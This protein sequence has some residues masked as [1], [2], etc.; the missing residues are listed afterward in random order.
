MNTRLKRI[1]LAVVAAAILLTA[2]IGFN[3][4]DIWRA[5]LF[6]P[7]VE[8]IENDSV[9]IGLYPGGATSA[10]VFTNDDYCGET[11]LAEARDLREWL[12]EH[13]LLMTFFVIP[14]HQDR[15]RLG[16]GPRLEIL[17]GLAADGH[18]I[19]QHGYSH[20]CEKNRGT[21]LKYGAE[22]ALLDRDEAMER[23]ERGRKILRECGFD[24]VG[25]RSPCFSGTGET[26]AALNRL[27]FLYGSDRNLPA[28]TVRNLI[29]Q[30]FRGSV[31]HP[32]HPEGMSLLEITGQT[33]PTV[34]ADKA[35]RIFERFH[36]RGGVIVYLTHL[37]QIGLPENLAKLGE[38]LEFVREHDTWICR[39]DELARWWLAREKLQV[40]IEREG[41]LTL[42]RIRNDS[43]YPLESARIDIR[44]AGPYRVIDSNSR[45]VL[46][47][48]TGPD[49]FPADIPAA[50][51]VRNLF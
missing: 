39:F 6:C 38:F 33:D 16:E 36:P 31:I 30:G 19:A 13:D 26:F 42:V 34:D 5:Y 45:E 37:P 20:C 17:R 44:A 49:S 11:P 43:P 15:S 2:W 28:T 29:F 46:R 3:T 47:E 51:Y 24:P 21:S 48:G 14:F 8:F 12:R 25:H 50:L 23:I 35:R 10:T 41:E 9:R 18:E 32:F 22:M 27:G 40:E 1:I 7:P 4:R